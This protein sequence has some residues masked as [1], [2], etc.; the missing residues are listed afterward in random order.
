M[1]RPAV[2][3]LTRKQSAYFLLVPT[4]VGVKNLYPPAELMHRTGTL[5]S[6]HG[7]RADVISELVQSGGWV[8]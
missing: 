5:A 6:F 3:V 4:A 1:R 2:R 8:G 7:Q